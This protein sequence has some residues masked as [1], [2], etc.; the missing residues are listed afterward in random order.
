MVSIL[1]AKS[2]HLYDKFCFKNFKLK[3]NK[4]KITS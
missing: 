1:V 3:I 2:Q 4:Y